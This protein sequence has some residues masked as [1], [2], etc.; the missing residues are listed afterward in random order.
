[1]KGAAFRR[2][3]RSIALAI[4]IPAYLIVISVFW[5]Y[6]HEA[7]ETAVIW[8]LEIGQNGLTKIAAGYEEIETVNLDFAGGI[9]R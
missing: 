2:A 5:G 7:K 3:S 9:R 1:L 8:L 6:G 4:Y